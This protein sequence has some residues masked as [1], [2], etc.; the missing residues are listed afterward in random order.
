MRIRKF[1]R[2]LEVGLLLLGPD[3]LD[4]PQRADLR[5]DRR[6]V[7]GEG[8]VHDTVRFRRSGQKTASS[9]WRRRAANASAEHSSRNAL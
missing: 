9:G 5:T 7:L 6:R 3:V 1:P 4:E 2:P 8:I